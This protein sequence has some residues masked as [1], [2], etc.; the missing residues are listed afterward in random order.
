MPEVTVL[1]AVRNGALVLEATIA[2]VRRQTFA[3]L[4]YVIVD[5]ASDDETP[6]VVERAMRDDRRIRLI[7]RGDRGGPYAAANDGLRA[8]QGRFVARLDADDVA[9]P[10]RIEPQIEYLRQT[11]LRACASFYQAITPDGRLTSEI[12]RVAGGV[13]MLKWRLCVRH[14]LT[15]STACVERS[16][17]EQIGGYRELPASQDL[18]LWCDL[19]RR[20]WLG[21]LPEVLIHLRRPGGVTSNTPE[22]QERLAIEVQFDHVNELSSDPWSEEEVRALRPSWTGQPM[23]TRLDA[24]DRWVRLWQSD[25]S[26][27]RRDRAE[28]SS[29][30]RSVYWDIA[31]QALRWEGMKPATLRSILFSAPGHLAPRTL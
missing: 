21:I 19:A 9:L 8:A 14:G 6:E 22:V 3:D 30:E 27:D 26:L 20:D 23:A 15:H 11:G 2:S 16:A 13:R 5:D 1:T 29:L 31:R 28:L 24:L 12:G 10:E 17:L 7:R 18:R 25:D 4:E